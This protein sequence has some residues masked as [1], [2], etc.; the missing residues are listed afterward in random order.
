VLRPTGPAGADH[1]VEM[2]GSENIGRSLEAIALGGPI[3]IVGLLGDNRLGGPMGMMLF[4]HAIAAAIAS[5]IFR[6]LGSSY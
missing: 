3:S 6:L 4:T 1:I 5:D 2:A